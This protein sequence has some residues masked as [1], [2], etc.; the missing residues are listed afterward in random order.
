[1]MTN[2]QWKK[3]KAKEHNELYEESKKPKPKR[4]MTARERKRARH[5]R[6]MIAA[7]LGFA[8]GGV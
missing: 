7:G 5:A 1:M 6:F 4:E 3:Q 8:S 2:S